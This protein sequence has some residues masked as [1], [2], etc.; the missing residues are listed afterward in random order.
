MIKK[1]IRKFINKQN[2][3]FL[4]D[5]KSDISLPA[6]ITKNQEEYVRSL[7]LAV[8]EVEDMERFKK[9]GEEVSIMFGDGNTSHILYFSTLDLSVLMEPDENGWVATHVY[10]DII[11]GKNDKNNYSELEFLFQFPN[12]N[13][14]IAFVDENREYHWLEFAKIYKYKNK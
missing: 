9:Y 3:K 5:N 8:L 2:D 6:K 7:M 4:V 14:G 13:E 11:E 12:I 10:M 1:A